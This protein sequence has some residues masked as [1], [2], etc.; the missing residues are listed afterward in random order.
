MSSQ[1]RRRVRP[2]P[3]SYVR[4]FVSVTFAGCAFRKNRTACPLTEAL[5]TQGRAGVVGQKRQHAQHGRAPHRVVVVHGGPGGAGEMAP[6]ARRL[7]QDFG[8][9]EPLQVADSVEGQVAELR[10]CSPPTR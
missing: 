7:G 8:V 10:N 6:V 5:R 9:L 4:S 2:L 1:V 3:L